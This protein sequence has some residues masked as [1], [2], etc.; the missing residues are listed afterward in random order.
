[1]EFKNAHLWHTKYGSTTHLFIVSG[2]DTLF[3]GELD[4]VALFI[5]QR[6]QNAIFGDA[7]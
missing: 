4:D 1:M 7:L 3:G 5:N 2:N 6:E